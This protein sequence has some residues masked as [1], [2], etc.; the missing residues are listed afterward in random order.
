MSGLS[1]HVLDLTGGCPGAGVAV[2]VSRAAGAGWTVLASTTTD[3][4]GRAKLVQGSDLG[5][6]AYRLAFEIGAYFRSTGAATVDPGF[7]ETVVIEVNLSEAGRHY[8][9]PL[10][11]SPFGYSTYRGS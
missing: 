11:V 8:H 1:T 3:T 5:V 10:L 6:G 4:D 9:V 7:L 2:S